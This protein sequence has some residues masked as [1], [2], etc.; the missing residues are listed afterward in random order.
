MAAARIAQ[1]RWT[2]VGTTFVFYGDGGA[3][4]DEDFKRWLHDLQTQS[5]DRYVGGTGP[6]FL[7]SSVQRNSP[8]AVFE[9][10]GIPFAT[11]TD[12]R[13]V[14]GF[15]TAGSW[16]GMNIAAFAWSALPKAWQWLD[17]D[18][19]DAHDVER[20]LHRLVHRVNSAI[21]SRPAA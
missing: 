9:E 12:S 14:R 6:D 15:V 16:F 4:G 13:L 7:L 21:D 11:I 20:T 8:R 5:F 18:V 1:T 2:I 10:R 17:L 19:N 3:F